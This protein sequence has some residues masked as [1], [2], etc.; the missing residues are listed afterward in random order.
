[1][2][3]KKVRIKWN[4]VIPLGLSVILVLYLLISLI[5]GL[6]GPKTGNLDIYTIGNFNAKKTLDIINNEDRSQPIL[7]K[8]YNFYGESLNLYFESYGDD[9][10]KS[11]TLNGKSV[12]LKDLINSNNVVTFADLTKDVDNQINLNKLTPGFYSLYI[13]DGDVTFRAYYQ[14][15]LSVNNTLYTVSRY[16][17]NYKIEIIA[18]KHLFDEINSEKKKPLTDVLDQNY[19]YIKVTVAE[20]YPQYDIALSTS[21]ALTMSGISLVGEQVGDFIEAQQ[22][23]ELALKVKSELE[24]KGLRVLI[25]KDEYGQDIQFYGKGG[26]L[27][28][29][30]KSGAKYMIHLDMDFYGKTGIMYAN[31]SSGRMAKAIFNY[32][33]TETDIYP[34]EKYLSKCDVDTNGVTDLQYEIREAGGVVLSAGVYS[35]SSQKNTFAYNNK[36]GIDTTQIVT[37]NMSDSKARS[38]WSQQ[39]DKVASAIVKGILEYLQI[40]N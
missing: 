14:S 34:N 2:F 20:E 36:Y 28:K 24:A 27:E 17:K 15:V 16:G 37:I 31:R 4:V 23:Y 29:A 11:N 6:F 26:T 35:E 12:I 10:T 19:I 1:M 22:V 13:V 38:L 3:D 25:L 9:I 8:D 39:K 5:A 33:S 7:I 32:I 18:D 21:P 40:A 30:Y